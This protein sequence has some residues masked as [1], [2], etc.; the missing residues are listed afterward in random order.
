MI[1]PLAMVDGLLAR[2][3]RMRQEGVQS[4]T[5]DV[6]DTRLEIGLASETSSV[7]TTIPAPADEAVKVPDSFTRLKQR[8]LQ[9]DYHRRERAE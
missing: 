7:A 5:V 1:D 4:L 3:E 6:G 9:N 2:A 8:V